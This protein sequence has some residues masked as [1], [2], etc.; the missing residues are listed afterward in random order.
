MKIVVVGVGYVGL[1]N[2]ILL[3]QNHEGVAVDI[4]SEKVEML[5]SK[6]SPIVDVEI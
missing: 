1:S 5:S 2:T 6:V 4:I 3:A